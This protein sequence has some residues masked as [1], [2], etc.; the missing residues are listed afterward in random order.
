MR[1]QSHDC[2][3]VITIL[4]HGSYKTITGVVCEGINYLYVTREVMSEVTG[5]LMGESPED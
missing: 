1:A 5:G 3:V 4:S 2:H